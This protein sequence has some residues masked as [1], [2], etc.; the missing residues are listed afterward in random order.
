MHDFA[1]A[2]RAPLL[3]E[4][5][6]VE[7]NERHKNPMATIIPIPCLRDNY[8]Y[9]LFEEGALDCCVV[10]PSEA[11]P[12]QA[13]LDRREL[14]LRAILCTHHHPDHVGGNRALATSGVEVIAHASDLHRVPA[15]T[16]GVV[17]GEVLK[18]GA[19]TLSVRHVPGHTLGAV[20]YVGDGFAFTGDTLFC[21]GCGRLFEGTST[22]MVHSL[23]QVLGEL[24]DEWVIYCGHEYTEA[25]LRFA[26]TI[27]PKNE[28]LAARL[29]KVTERRQ[30]GLFCGAA[31]LGEERRTN[32]FL[33]VHTDQVSRAVEAQSRSPEHTFAALR[34][35][36]DR[37]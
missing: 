3:S 8:A 14:S 36:K 29:A 32:P 4:K 23:N 22:Q 1:A 33:R 30:R 15:A 7:F 18:L 34:S 21:G 5:R 25:N 28:L 11:A 9:L 24:P 17:H 2:A 26:A 16:R 13:E 27:E 37:A 6:A 35:L 20:A 10:D 19:L 12:V 31:S